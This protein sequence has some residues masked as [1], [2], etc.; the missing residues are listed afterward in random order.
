LKPYIAGEVLTVTRTVEERRTSEAGASQPGMTPE[1]FTAGDGVGGC[2]CRSRAHATDTRPERSSRGRRRWPS[3]PERSSRGGRRKRPLPERR[4]PSCG[5]RG[6]HRRL[7][8][9]AGD[10]AG[11]RRCRG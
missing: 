1:A 2:R 11:G 4:S 6:G 5:L 10:D 9:G 7:D 8:S 3:L